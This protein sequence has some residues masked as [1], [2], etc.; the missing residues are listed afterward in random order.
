MTARA[1]RKATTDIPIVYAVVVDPVS[2]GLATINR[3]PFGNMTGMTTYDPDQARMHIALLRSVKPD[4][5]RIALL[6]DSGV[7]NCLVEVHSAAM[8]EARVRPQVVHIAGPDPDLIGAFA[9][10]QREE[11]DALVV[12]EHP[13]NGANSARIAELAL[14]R[15]LPTGVARAQ[16]DAG[17]LFA[18]GTSLRDAAYQMARYASRILRGTE[19]SDLPV[20]TFH[21]A[22]LV[23][24]MRTARSL[25][26]TVPPDILF[27]A[28][29]LID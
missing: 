16:A 28:V 6:A 18:Y 10:M 14:V 9:A 1:A 22:E 19:P 7:S 11:A 29:C 24:N 15:C 25:G 3:Q 20:E 17:G 5:S 8:R 23:V 27:R 12:L 2:D 26:L 13:V 4:L 21:R